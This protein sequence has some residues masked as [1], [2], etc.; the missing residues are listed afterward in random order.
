[1]KIIKYV[2]EERPRIIF[3]VVLPDIIYSMYNISVNLEAFE[4]VIR[5][6]LNIHK[7]RMIN[8]VEAIQGDQKE[9]LI[10]VIYNKFSSQNILKREKHKMKEVK[11]FNFRI[12]NYDFNSIIDIETQIGFEEVLK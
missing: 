10:L 8:F 3:G 11:N 5:H 6:H 2:K 12:F 7:N 1:M 9:V 4:D